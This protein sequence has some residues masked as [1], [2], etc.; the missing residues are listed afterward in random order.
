M[1]KGCAKKFPHILLYDRTFNNK[2]IF[3]FVKV[4]VIQNDKNKNINIFN[5]F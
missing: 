1:V 2:I 5:V 3:I 4:I